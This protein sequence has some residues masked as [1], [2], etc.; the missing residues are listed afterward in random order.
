MWD[1]GRTPLKGF[2][3]KLLKQVEK[4]SSK[5]LELKGTLCTE[6]WSHG[7]Q[8]ILL[9]GKGKGE[10]EHLKNARRKMSTLS[11]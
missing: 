10:H 7:A 3:S 6:E 9:L 1:P 5:R 11:G 8:A 2:L 4:T